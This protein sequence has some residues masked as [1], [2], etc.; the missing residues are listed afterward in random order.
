MNEVIDV[1]KFWNAIEA[2]LKHKIYMHIKNIFQFS[3]LDNPTSIT[4]AYLYKFIEPPGPGFNFEGV[5]A[6]VNTE[7][8][9]NRIPEGANQ[10]D[11]YGQPLRNFD[12]GIF[13]FKIGD[14]LLINQIVNIVG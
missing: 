6:E 2:E 7:A 3:N 5:E 13:K 8:Y 1:T 14:K 11:Y 10:A 9:S 12:R 4:E